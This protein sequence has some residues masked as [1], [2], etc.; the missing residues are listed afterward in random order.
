ML[1]KVTDRIYYYMNNDEAIIE[2]KKI[3]NTEPNSDD[4]FFIKSFG[5]GKTW[6]REMD[7]K[8]EIF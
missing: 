7:L 3:Y 6:G 2:F 8:P 5:V 4:I 1:E